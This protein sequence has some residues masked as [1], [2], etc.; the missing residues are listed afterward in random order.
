MDGWTDRPT[1]PATTVQTHRFSKIGSSQFFNFTISCWPGL[2]TP[3]SFLFPL[4]LEEKRQRRGDLPHGRQLLYVRHMRKE[5]RKSE[6]FWRG[7]AKRARSPLEEQ[8]VLELDDLFGEALFSQKED[9]LHTG[10]HGTKARWRGLL[11]VTTS[12]HECTRM[13]ACRHTY[14]KI[15]TQNPDI[16][17]SACLQAYAPVLKAHSCGYRNNTAGGP[18]FGWF[19]QPSDVVMDYSIL[20]VMALTANCENKHLT[21]FTNVEIVFSKSQKQQNDDRMKKNC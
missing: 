9:Q 15:C 3:H 7:L 17:S 4:L 20:P 19:T 12:L 11:E 16:N 18:S 8:W 5:R 21:N 6:I 10:S 1:S 14:T 13:H 2:S